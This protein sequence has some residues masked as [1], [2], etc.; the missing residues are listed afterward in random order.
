V[1]TKVGRADDVLGYV[2]FPLDFDDHLDG[3]RSYG[4]MRESG[5]V[6]SAALLSGRGVHLYLFLEAPMPV[7]EA[8]PVARR[9][10]R[11]LGSDGVHDEPRIMRLPGTRNP[12]PG[13][14]V[15]VCRVVAFT[16]ARYGLDEVVAVLDRAG[17]PA[18]PP[19]TSGPGR[20]GMGARSV[21]PS[22]WP[23]TVEG[24]ASRPRV[25]ALL[26]A[27]SARMQR[28]VLSGDHAAAGYRSR[29]RATLALGRALARAGATDDEIGVVLLDHPI[30]AEV[31]EKGLRRLQRIIA[32]V[33]STAPPEDISTVKVIGLRGFTG[34]RVD[35]QVE[36]V[37]GADRGRRWWQ[38]VA[39]IADLQAAI[40]AS[41]GLEPA[42]AA[43]R[44]T[45]GLLG[46]RLHV[47]V[48]ERRWHGR[49]QL[50]VAFWHARDA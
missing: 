29:S 41:A 3:K 8:Q 22:S 38:H 42:R 23:V 16:G 44:W 32:E 46:S 12:K 20:G 15:P 49:R 4:R 19:R 37:A 10:C 36:V 35:L 14:A 43:S 33:R 7:A 27:L 5:L 50:E 6:P 18:V 30:G 26:D 9:L 21:P 47:R 39:P 2:A 34:G 25:D 45:D 40:R 17:A 13:V 24:Q 31:R 1:G 48:R 28:L 11:W